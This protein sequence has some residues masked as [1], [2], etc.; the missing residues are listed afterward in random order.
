MRF[1]RSSLKNLIPFVFIIGCA[2][3]T[4]PPGQPSPVKDKNVAASSDSKS[5][6]SGTGEAP[7]VQG[8]IE[9]ALWTVASTPLNIKC[10]QPADLGFKIS[11]GMSEANRHMLARFAMLGIEPLKFESSILQDYFK[12]AGFNG[13]KL[14]ENVEKGVQGIV[15]WSDKI[16]V[17]VFRG[18]HSTNGIKTDLN[19]FMSANSFAAMP[20]G[21]HG[22]FKAA[23]DSVQ[24]ALNSALDVKGRPGVPTYYIG[25]SLGGA[26]AMLAATDGLS[27]GVKV[28]G[29]VTLGQPRT[30]NV[31]YAANFSSVLR[32]KYFRY[33]NGNDPVPHLPPAPAAASVAASSI[34]NNDLLKF[35]LQASALLRFGH[36]GVP[37]QIANSNYATAAYDSDD[38]WDS[39]YWSKNGEPL[40]Q[41]LTS[42]LT[43]GSSI[44]L[45]TL[46]QSNIV[47]DHDAEKY[48]CGMLSNLK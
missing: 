20:G 35:G 1:V 11:E 46:T 2:K 17:V 44:S 10:Q 18:T 4:N 5:S 47:G 32:E 38:K 13:V 23:F 24:P 48:L 22:G 7:A 40:R 26:L 19:F 31:N 9:Q 21:L 30:G 27:K 33:V 6:D 37:V 29:L 45:A 15:A 41:S 43:S 36:V 14:L 16:N 8:P 3:T 39:S 34:T 12:K 28:E 25:H 42:M